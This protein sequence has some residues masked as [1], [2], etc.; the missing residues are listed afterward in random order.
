M[1]DLP[2]PE[3][4]LAEVIE[5]KVRRVEEAEKVV[6]KC[7]E[8]LEKEKEKLR[9]CEA[10][11]DKVKNHKQAKVDQL[12]EMYDAGTTSDKIK[13]C[14]VYI[15]VVHEKLEE[16]E[17]KVLAQKEEVKAAEKSLE[18]AKED[19]RLKRKEVEKLE[20]H[21][22]EWTKEVKKELQL[23]EAIQQNELGSI[24]FINQ[25]RWRKRE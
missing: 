13:Q 19:L 8:A 22:E 12:R 1:T 10:A 15:A 2:M 11:R 6:L 24:M 14:K 18:A 9:K 5:I 16:E 17:K 4:P 7:E 23:K 21:R 3:Y 25:M 20:T